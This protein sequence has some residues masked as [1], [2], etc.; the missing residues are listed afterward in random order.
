MAPLLCCVLV[1]INALF[2]VLLVICS[3][4]IVAQETNENEQIRYDVRGRWSNDPQEFSF[5]DY[6]NESEARARIEELRRDYYGENGLL[7]TAPNKPV[8]LRV[9]PFKLKG[10]IRTY[11]PSPTEANSFVPGPGRKGNIPGVTPP[12]PAGLAGVLG[13]FVNTPLD[14]VFNKQPLSVTFQ[15][16]GEVRVVVFRDNQSK[17]IAQGSWSISGNTLRIRTRAYDYEGRIEGLEIRGTRTI[18]EVPENVENWVIRLPAETARSSAPV[19]SNRVTPDSSDTA[20]GADSDSLRP[21]VPLYVPSLPR[22]DSRRREGDFGKSTATPGSSGTKVPGTSTPAGA[23]TNGSAQGAPM[24]APGKGNTGARLQ[25]NENA[26]ESTRPIDADD[27]SNGNAPTSKSSRSDKTGSLRP[28]ADTI[29]REYAQLNRD[30]EQN[31]RDIQQNIEAIQQNI[32]DIRENVEKMKENSRNVEE[33]NRRV[34]EF[35][36]YR[37]ERYP[38]VNGVYQIPPAEFP[39]MQAWDARIEAFRR[40]VNAQIDV[41][42]KRKAELDRRAAET[43]QRRMATERRAAEISRRGA[44]LERRANELKP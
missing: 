2:V 3:T 23:S 12:V 39:A 11:L 31:N 26:P 22:V 4:S 37:R 30:T 8:D 25:F 41:T 21:Q 14:G 38:Q 29:V 35:D 16:R 15:Q 32:R 24:S 28:D 10:G 5:G 44:E 34:A 20:A 40:E 17:I 18:R 42:N 36:R 6:A 1:R 9:V 33:L 43:E 27:A 19:Q 7:R 13:S